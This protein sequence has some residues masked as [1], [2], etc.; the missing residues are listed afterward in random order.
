M[1]ELVDRKKTEHFKLLMPAVTAQTFHCASYHGTDMVQER[2][3]AAAL[4]HE[5]GIFA[6][7]K[8]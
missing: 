8:S 2:G 4:R 6:N 1:G 7:L 3:T 5:S